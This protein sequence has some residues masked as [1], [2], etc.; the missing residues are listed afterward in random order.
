MKHAIDFNEGWLDRR[1]IADVRLDQLGTR[2][3]I[4]ALAVSKLSS[5]RTVRPRSSSASVRLDPIKP[6]PPVTKTVLPA[7]RLLEL[8]GIA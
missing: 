4:L 5:T 2:V 6:A 8:F 1:E 3:K 7:P